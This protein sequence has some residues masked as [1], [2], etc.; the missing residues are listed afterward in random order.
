MPWKRP[1]A[2]ER[3]DQIVRLGGMPRPT[4]WTPP[5]TAGGSKQQYRQVE[6]DAPAPFDVSVIALQ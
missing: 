4:E 3:R 6:G 2:I 1:T 5:D